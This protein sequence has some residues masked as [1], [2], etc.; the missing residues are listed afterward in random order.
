[1][2]KPDATPLTA[3]FSTS[4]FPPEVVAL[5]AQL[6]A[7]NAALQAELNSSQAELSNSQA[8]LIHHQ[9]E[10]ARLKS[11]R[12]QLEA[13]LA[14]AWEQIR[15]FIHDRWMPSS[16]K[17][18]ADVQ[19]GLFDE[20]EQLVESDQAESEATIESSST[21]EKKKRGSRAPL[22]KELPRK[23]VIID[24]AD[25]EK[26]C[27]RDGAALV[28][29]GKDISE[30]LCIIPM[31]IFVEQIILKKY[32]CPVCE[33][34]VKTAA[35]PPQLIPKS[36]ASPSLL[37]YLVVA[38][39]MDGL[40]L[41]RLEQIF[42]KRMGVDLPRTTQA[43]WMLQVSEAIQPLMDQMKI[44]LLQNSELIH[45]DET[46]LQVNREEGRLPHNKSYMWV[47]KG[48]PPEQPVVFFNYD[49]GR[50]GRVAQALLGDYSGIL[51]TD[52]Y[53]AYTAVA[54]KNQITHAGCWV[55]ARR[56]FIEAQKAQP[57][58]KTGKADW[59]ISQIKQLYA[60]ERQAK[61]N[62][63]SSEQHLEKRQTE[64]QPII[65]AIKNWLDKSLRHTLPKGKLGTALTYLHNQW[66]HLILFLQDSRI[67]L[68]NN[69]AENAI[70][71]FVIGRK[72]WLFSDTP[73][74]AQAS[75][76]LYSLIET[77]KANGI[78]PYSYLCRVFEELPKA[79][80][81]EDLKALLPWK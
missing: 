31:Q 29:I 67:P 22:P 70:R 28:C 16:E 65:N 12:D 79:K 37:A 73:R 43:R 7:Q 56:K 58:G 60:I 4:D 51:V 14:L 80:T 18:T 34:G 62:S 24:L 1:M 46:T 48:G 20:A 39:Y 71:P 72:N 69:A 9:S 52:G 5:M 81:E 30:R 3:H 26:I 66:N 76:N 10:V 49:S 23:T 17:E 55:H 78:E 42:Q 13:E 68:D 74:G 44:H 32:A 50:S 38:K 47:Q 19:P 64:S 59:I 45:M 57:K 40:P 53:E 77:A 15:A 61:E 11:E 35:V 2:K 75:A 33:D 21:P 27:P 8:E 41:Y 25:D 6:Q 63:F 36:N 54:Q